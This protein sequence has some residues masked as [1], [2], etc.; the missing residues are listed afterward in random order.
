MCV[1][2]LVKSSVSDIAASPVSN[3]GESSTMTKEAESIDLKIVIDDDDD[4]GAYS[5]SS[6]EIVKVVK[7]TV[8][9]ILHI[10]LDNIII[11]INEVYQFTITIILFNVL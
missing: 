6:I 10:N 11:M 5:D 8:F 4:D 9:I 7:V 1:A 3:A 2:D